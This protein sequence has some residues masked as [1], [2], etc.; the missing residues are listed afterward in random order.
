MTMGRGDSPD[1][2]IRGE[3]AEVRWLDE[4]GGER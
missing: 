4:P 3:V 2:P 1:K